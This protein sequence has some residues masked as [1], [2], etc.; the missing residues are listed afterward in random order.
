MR[1]YR[2]YEEWKPS[3]LPIEEF[4]KNGSYRTYEEW[5]PGSS[6]SGKT[7]YAKFLP[8][9]WGM[10]TFE[11]DSFDRV[12]H[13]VLTVPMRNGNHQTISY[14]YQT[15]S[16]LTVPMRN[17]NIGSSKE[18]EGANMFLPYLWG[19]E[20][21]LLLS[22][23]IL[24]RCVLT[25]PMRNGNRILQ[26]IINMVIYVLTVP[27]RNGNVILGSM[28]LCLWKVLTVPMRNGNLLTSQK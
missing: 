10:E 22:L 19:M 13:G 3:I 20:T 15:I 12:E 17:G 28:A 1:S 25:V 5:K 18:W 4:Y 27:M 26:M 24:N 7:T 23:R 14:L 16:V 8:Y 9:L 11:F 2:T 21:L 6:G